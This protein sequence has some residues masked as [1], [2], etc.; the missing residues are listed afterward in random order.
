MVQV[1]GL[2]MSE[3]SINTLIISTGW[4]R[5]TTDNQLPHD[6]HKSLIKVG[7]ADKRIHQ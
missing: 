1:R 6:E 4:L 3:I 5:A 2:N 7:L